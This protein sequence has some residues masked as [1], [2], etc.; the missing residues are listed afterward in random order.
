MVD[1][2]VDEDLEVV[3]FRRGLTE[4]QKE[5]I[6]AVDTVPSSLID[7]ARKAFEDYGQAENGQ[8]QNS[9]T[10]PE[11]CTTYEHK[12]FDGQKEPPLTMFY[13]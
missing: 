3:D 9:E 12:D 7:S 10:M 2:E 4:A 11:P 1:P 6:V 5:S 13:F 8:S